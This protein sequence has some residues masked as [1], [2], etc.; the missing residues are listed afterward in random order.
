MIVRMLKQLWRWRLISRGLEIAPD[1]RFMGWQTF[2]S[3]PYLVRIGKHVTIA[4]HVSF[5]THDGG[6]WVFRDQP[7]YRNVIKYGRIVIHDNCFIGAGTMILP[8]ISI[9]PNAVVAAGSVV[10]KS[11]PPNS[12][13][14]GVPA[15]V[16]RTVEEYANDALRRTPEYN[17]EAYAKN[18]KEELLR[19]IPIPSAGLNQIGALGENVEA[20]T[21]SHSL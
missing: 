9:G 20:S 21:I 11:I 10:T 13:A 18:K 5:I 3:E 4:S 19:I 1:S 14:A 17:R 15:R 16:L 12:V 6:T 8:G 7:S 2:G